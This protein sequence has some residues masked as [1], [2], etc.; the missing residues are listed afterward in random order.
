[1]PSL[2][3]LGQAAYRLLYYRINVKGI[4]AIIPSRPN[5]TVDETKNAVKAIYKHFSGK[6]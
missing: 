5:K 4:P 6:L 1:V 2:Q 3:R